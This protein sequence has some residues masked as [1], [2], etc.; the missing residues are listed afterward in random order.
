MV[1]NPYLSRL[2]LYTAFQVHIAVPMIW[3]TTCLTQY[4]Q[5]VYLQ[6]ADRYTSPVH[7]DHANMSY[8]QRQNDRWCSLWGLQDYQLDI[9]STTW[10]CRVAGQCCSSMSLCPRLAPD[11]WRIR[12]LSCAKLCILTSSPCLACWWHLDVVL[13]SHRF[14]CSL[15]KWPW[16][17]SS[18]SDQ[19]V[20]SHLQSATWVWSCASFGWEASLSW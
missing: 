11:Q 19:F 2:L 7:K 15:V 14:D 3:S 12:R 4:L 5:G 13:A 16:F 6:G 18:D 9:W 20:H 1:E 8:R 10:W 17:R